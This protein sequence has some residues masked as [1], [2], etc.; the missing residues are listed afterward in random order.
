MPIPG[1]RRRARSSPTAPPSDDARRRPRRGDRLLGRGVA[2]SAGGEAGWALTRRPS[3]GSPWSSG[4]DRTVSPGPPGVRPSGWDRGHSRPHPPDA[5]SGGGDQGAGTLTGS[6]P[7]GYGGVGYEAVGRDPGGRHVPDQPAQRRPRRAGT[8]G[9]GQPRPAPR[10]GPR[11]APARLRPLVG[12]ARLRLPRWRGLGA[13]AVPPRRDGQG[14]DDHEPAHRGQPA[15]LPPRDRHPVRPRRRLG[16]LGRAAGRRR[17]TGTASH[18]A[19]TSWSP[20]G[21]TRSSSSGP[22]WTT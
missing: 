8:R 20:A 22:G 12:G 16:H 19:T 2:P 15:Q 4:H 1:R 21:S 5:Q 7:L 3:L 10:A 6:G 11:V 9:R 14:R 18:C 13:G 17:R